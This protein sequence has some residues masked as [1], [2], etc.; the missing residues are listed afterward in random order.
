[1]S[2][3]TIV[4][5]IRND[6]DSDEI[7]KCSNV[8]YKEGAISMEIFKTIEEYGEH[9]QIVYCRDVN[10]GLKGIIAIHNT[11]LGPG[12]G[13]VRMHPYQNEN[14]ALI[15]VL[16]VSRGM[17]YK[18][19]AAG[20]NLGGGKAVIM[21]DPKEDKS[22]RLF[23]AFGQYVNSLK[24]KYIT[25]EDVGMDVA[26]MEY[27]YMETPF[28]TGIPKTLG[29]SGDPS[30]FTARG[31]YYGIK[32]SVLEKLNRRSLEGLHIAVQGAGHVGY[33]LIEL[34]V[35][36]GAFVSVADV[37]E[38]KARRVAEEFNVILGSAE[39][40]VTSKCD[41]LAPCALGSVIHEENVQKL[42]CKVV[43]GAANNQLSKP[44]LADELKKLDILY[45]PDFVLNSGGV[46]NVSVELEGYSKERAQEKVNKIYHKLLETYR[47]AKKKEIS[48]L[49][50]ANHM[51][52]NRIQSIQ[53]LKPNHLSPR[54]NRRV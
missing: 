54:V 7:K 21:G 31:V 38:E 4:L 39:D 18:A 36:E 52:E 47:I 15:D 29:G 32:A 12:L 46:I 16:R 40:I 10:S 45:A 50:A 17:T 1:M 9:E 23:R 19:A 44:S 11:I 53:T 5:D 26:D 8:Q 37:D 48:T 6:K 49:E 27:I 13:G 22:E 41:V 2:R 28:V 24:G 34:L 42:Q 35:K 25:A 33:H 51:A 14:E 30:V 20:L 43:A 3:K